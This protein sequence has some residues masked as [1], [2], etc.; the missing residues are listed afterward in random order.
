MPIGYKKKVVFSKKGSTASGK[1]RSL[2]AF[3]G[4]D[5]KKRNANQN[6]EVHLRCLQLSK[7]RHEDHKWLSNRCRLIEMQI[8]ISSFSIVSDFRSYTTK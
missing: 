7:D 4:R 8:R 5:N 3:S 2:V 1:G 6:I